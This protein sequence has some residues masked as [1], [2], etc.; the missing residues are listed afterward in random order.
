M[1][2]ER[3]EE[4]EEEEISNI[5]NKNGLIDNE[6]LMRKT[7]FKERNINSDLVKKYFFTYDLQDM[8]KNFRKSKTNSERNKIQVITIKNGLR[9]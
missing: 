2:F 3:E 7:G 1:R 8:Q 5:R 4:K 9:D 6:K